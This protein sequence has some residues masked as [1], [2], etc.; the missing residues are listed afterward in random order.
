MCQKRIL[1]ADNKERFLAVRSELLENAGYMVVQASTLEEAER[2]LRETWVHLAILDNRLVDDDDDEDFSGLLLAQ[3]GAYSGIP[4]IM[5]TGFPTADVV[6]EALRPAVDSLPPTINFVSKEEGV[7][8][9][10][11]AVDRAFEK[12]V[13]INW[14]LVIQSDPSF[15][16]LVDK[17][18]P[19]LSNKIMLQRADEL[20]DL[21][22]RLFY[23]EY[24]QIRIDRLLWATGGRCCLRVL[25]QT[26]EQAVLPRVVVCGEREKLRQE[27]KRMERLAPQTFSSTKRIGEADTTH[28]GATAYV[29]PDADIETVQPLKELF[30]GDRERPVKTAFTNLLDV[31]LEDWHKKGGGVSEAQDLMSQYRK[32]AGLGGYGLSQAEV[33]CKIEALIQALQ[34]LG[35][36][37]IERSGGQVVFRFPSLPLVTYPDPVAAAYASL[38]GY[39]GPIV[40]LVSPGSLTFDDVLVDGKQGVWLSDFAQAGQAPR[41]W[42]FICLEAAVRF[43]LS[44]PP[45]W[46]ACR[47]FEECLIEPD[48]LSER[49]QAHEVVSDLKMSVAVIEQI[50]LQANSEAGSD[51]L[52][53]Y[54]GLL[55]WAVGKMA[56][57][58]TQALYTWVDLMPKAHMLLA[59]CMIAKRMS[60]GVPD[61]PLPVP[62]S[63]TTLRLDDNG[64]VWIGG[65]CVVTL[66]GQELALLRCLYKRPEQIVSRKVIADEVFGERY[67]EG[68]EQMNG[69]INTLVRRLRKS[70]ESNPNNPRCILTARG[71][72]YRLHNAEGP[73]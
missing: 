27:R 59:A 30:L 55:V 52:P 62:P 22:R 39:D 7:D 60:E 13:R 57:Y 18:Q 47:E 50:R 24:K 8:A 6:R 1:F 14:N 58:D 4:K 63:E 46:L 35:P 11:Q 42:D 51:V 31:I 19:D 21:I 61:S 9:L 28:F 23:G 68:D 49:L 29:L 72:G 5:L 64:D 32:R 40:S 16:S 34:T 65:R 69:R 2:H 20:E 48:I 45:D 3:D 41:L 10:I 67:R 53:H 38:A 70:V 36:V 71:K 25:A 15:L 33:D 37:G 12:Y 26:S 43:K 56:R 17:I 66:E 54:A 73:R 44:N